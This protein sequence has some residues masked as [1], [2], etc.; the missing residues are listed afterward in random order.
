MSF[1]AL[2]YLFRKIGYRNLSIVVT[3]QFA[4][5]GDAVNGEVYVFPCSLRTGAAALDCSIYALYMLAISPGY[6]SSGYNI[7]VAA[8]ENSNLAVLAYGR[9]N[10]D[11]SIIVV[12]VF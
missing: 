4:A 11:I 6:A 12:F 1:L 5:I 9:T 10:A 2:R 8:N 7:K 3:Y